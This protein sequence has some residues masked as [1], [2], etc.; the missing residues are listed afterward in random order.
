MLMLE[1]PPDAP[2]VTEVGV[3]VTVAP[4]GSPLAARATACVKLP[5]TEL[6]M[7]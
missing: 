6:T 1:V 7:T 2:G 5:F 3:N 4:G